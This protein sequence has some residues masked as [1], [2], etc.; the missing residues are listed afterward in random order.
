MA[1][2]SGAVNQPA[3]RGD[4]AGV[5]A[6]LDAGGDVNA[7]WG[8]WTPLVRAA[9]WGHADVAALLIARGADVDVHGPDCNTPLVSAVAGRRLAIVRALVAAGAD[10]GSDDGPGSRTPVHVAAGG[11]DV[12]S[13]A[14]LLASPRADRVAAA[15]GSRD[16][17][18][19]GVMH[20]WA[21]AAE[22]LAERGAT[23]PPGDVDAAAQ[24][25]RMLRRAGARVDVPSDASVPG[26]PVFNYGRLTFVPGGALP[27][28]GLQAMAAGSGADAAAA[29]ATEAA[30]SAAR[31][32]LAARLLAA[33]TAAATDGS[34]EGP[35]AAPAAAAA[36]VGVDLGTSAGAG[37]PEPKR[38]RLADA[39][40]S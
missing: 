10:V 11:H 39:G 9:R 6:A 28:A 38:P 18:G 2:W 34:G 27:L 32:A 25:A 15:V 40:N 14:M 3:E 26:L 1:T 19:R 24:V 23:A 4:V 13:L 5:R 17:Y 16:H 30:A 8:H 7:A 21:E 36:A 31:R 37:A 33:A 35:E 22:V 12:E 29:T 20:E